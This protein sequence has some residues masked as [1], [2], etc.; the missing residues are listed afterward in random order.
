MMNYLL[1]GGYVLAVSVLIATPGPNAFLMITHSLSYGNKAIVRN[2]LGGVSAALILMALA[3][4]GVA[5][6]VPQ[7]ILPYLSLLGG[8]YL[9][10][11]GL[12]NWNN[13]KRIVPS[14]DE[15]GAGVMEPNFFR[16]AFLAGI[17]NPKDLLFFILFLPQFI[18]T[19]VPLWQGAL[20][21][22]ALWFVCDFGIMSA[23]GLVAGQ[24][25]QFLTPH[26]QWFL[27][28][29]LSTI[30]MGLGLILLLSTVFSLLQ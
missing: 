28:R 16:E 23:V 9:F 26:R 8:A 10:V 24:L 22:M 5:Q 3:L 18:D 20:V 13:A 6:F 27:A 11:L 4:F 21:L 15:H 29:I 25:K 30:M 19:S 1:L 14:E 12:K 2:A 17:S 7:S